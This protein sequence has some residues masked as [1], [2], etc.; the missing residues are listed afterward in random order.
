M[1]KVGQRVFYLFASKGESEND[2]E[3]HGEIIQV[4]HKCVRI[5]WDNMEDLQSYGHNS[6]ITKHLEEGRTVFDSNNP[7]TTF[8]KIKQKV[9]RS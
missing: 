3:F 1:W 7:N 4:N 8:R 2:K 6:Y 9:D 5:K